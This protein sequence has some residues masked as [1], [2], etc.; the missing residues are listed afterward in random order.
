MNL[1]KNLT[2]LQGEFSVFQQKQNGNMRLVAEIKE[3]VINIVEVIFCLMWH[4]GG[5]IVNNHIL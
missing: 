4:G 5:Q 1:L 2:L 3:K